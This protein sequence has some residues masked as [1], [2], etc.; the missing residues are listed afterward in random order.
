M[1]LARTIIQ[2]VL[3]AVSVICI[4]VIDGKTVFLIYINDVSNIA[5]ATRNAWAVVQAILYAATIGIIAVVNRI[6]VMKVQSQGVAWVAS[7]M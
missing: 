3:H 1:R 2:A 7:T 4:A 5:G 6:T